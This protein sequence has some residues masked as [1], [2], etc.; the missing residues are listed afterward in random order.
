MPASRWQTSMA[1]MFEWMG[2]ADDELKLLVPPVF[3]RFAKK[4]E[5]PEANDSQKN[6]ALKNPEVMPIHP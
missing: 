2:E 6:E 4:E 1:E 3:S 5:S